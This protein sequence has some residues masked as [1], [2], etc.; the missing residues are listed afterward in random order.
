LA[1]AFPVLAAISEDV[2]EKG[3]AGFEGGFAVAGLGEFGFGRDE[4]AFTGGFE[5]GGAVAL[6]VGLN[7][8]E[9][10]EA[11]V[12]ARELLLNLRHDVTLFGEW[13]QW[14]IN[15]ANVIEPKTDLGSTAL[16][17]PELLLCWR[18]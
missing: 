14:Y 4:V 9:R 1:T 5:Y 2:G 15:G 10:R 7:P 12:Q 11:H 16:K 6:E 18:A 13:R 17:L 3:L 8:S